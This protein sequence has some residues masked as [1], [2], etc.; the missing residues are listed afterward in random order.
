MDKETLVTQITGIISQIDVEVSLLDGNEDILETHT[1]GKANMVVS[2][3]ELSA[4]MQD[5]YRFSVWAIRD[6]WTQEPAKDDLVEISSVQ[7]RVMNKVQNIE[8]SAIRLDLG[9]KFQQGY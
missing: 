5:S 3:R 7:Y 1:C 2:E 9:A 4:G 6:D 8:G